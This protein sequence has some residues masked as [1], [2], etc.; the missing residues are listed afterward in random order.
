MLRTI[1]SHTNNDL[2]RLY[3]RHMITVEFPILFHAVSTVVGT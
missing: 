1:T 3:Y 2:T